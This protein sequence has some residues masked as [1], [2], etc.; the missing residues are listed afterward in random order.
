MECVKILLEHGA[1]ADVVDVNNSTPLHLSAANG[2]IDI[3]VLLL[4]REAKVDAKDKV[5]FWHCCKV[6]TDIESPGNEHSIKCFF[7]DTCIQY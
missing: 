3:A 4:E 2:D 7:L 6:Q 1:Q 5:K